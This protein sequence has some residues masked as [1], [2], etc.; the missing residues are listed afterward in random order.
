MRLFALVLALLCAC[1]TPAYAAVFSETQN[2]I[3]FTASNPFGSNPTMV[4]A[5]FYDDF[6]L[7]LSPFTISSSYDDAAPTLEQC[8]GPGPSDCYL[9]TTSDASLSVTIDGETFSSF[10]FTNAFLTPAEANSF[11]PIDGTVFPAL[12]NTDIGGVSAVNTLGIANV[13]RFGPGDR[14]SLEGVILQVSLPEALN[15]LPDPL[16]FDGFNVY[17]QGVARTGALLIFDNDTATMGYAFITNP[18]PGTA[19]LMGLGLMGLAAAGRR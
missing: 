11:D 6:P 3:T 10:D 1:C 5:E 9:I 7:A 8:F 16:D 12:V 13:N 18:E 2:S 19:I 4:N 17:T 14:W 15:L